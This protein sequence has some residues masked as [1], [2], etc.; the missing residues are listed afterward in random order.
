[1]FRK[2]PLFR[3]KSLLS[4][5]S[6]RRLG[7]GW[8]AL[9]IVGIFLADSVRVLSSVGV[10]GLFCTGVVYG[11]YHQRIAQR[12]HWPS[13][14]SFGPIYFLHALTGLLHSTHAE[15]ALRQDL[16]LQLPF[17]LL[18]I[19]FLLLPTWQQNHK[20]VLWLLLIGCCLLSAGSATAHYLSHY[21]AINQL[22]LRSQ[23]MPTSPDHIRFSLLGC[24]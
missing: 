17:L 19:S 14:L 24:V 7:V 3:V 8:S 6:V 10:A 18:P 20:T 9:I 22:Y 21:K 4:E 23:V 12:A 15:T 2:R 5:S 1:M 13:L 16:V 11:M